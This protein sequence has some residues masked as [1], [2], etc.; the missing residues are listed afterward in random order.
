MG[1][2]GFNPGGGEQITW[3]ALLGGGGR[4]YPMVS[5]VHPEAEAMSRQASQNYDKP[6]MKIFR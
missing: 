5:Q 1:W 4:L 3:F 6:A 2:T